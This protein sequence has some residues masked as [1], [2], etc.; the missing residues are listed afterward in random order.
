MTAD[1]VLAIWLFALGFPV[2]WTQQKA[3]MSKEIF[4]K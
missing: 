3:E 2:W 4:G 1:I